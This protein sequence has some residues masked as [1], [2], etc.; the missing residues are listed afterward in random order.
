MNVK[1]AEI[2]SGFNPLKKLQKSSPGKSFGPKTLLRAI[3]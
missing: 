3:Q 2:Y 1:K